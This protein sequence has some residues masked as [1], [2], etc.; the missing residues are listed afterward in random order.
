MD[1]DVARH[2]VVTDL[3][4]SPVHVALLR[5]PDLGSVVGADPVPLVVALHGGAQGAAFADTIAVLASEAWSAG[6]LPPCVIALPHS[7]RS[8]WVDR[9]DGSARWETFVRT[10]LVDEVRALD[11]RCAD[12]P[13]GLLGVSMGGLGVLRLAF[14]YP[15]QFAAVA[16]LEPGIDAGMTWDDIDTSATSVRG[17]AFYEQFHGSPVDVAHFDANHPPAIAVANHDAIVAA[18]IQIYLECG[19]EDALKLY[20]A[21]EL[22][23]RL[24]WDHGI[25]HEYHLVRGADHLGQSLGRRFNEALAFLGRA[26]VPPPPD[27]QVEALRA[28]LA[29]GASLDAV[30]G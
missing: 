23:H 15:E 5:H 9:F 8:F 1:V 12:G 25:K 29:S 30:G 24:L 22:L 11:P 14:K 28:F 13:T 6:D 21:A 4:P 26:F 2:E 19:D 27:P 16:A 17:D 3:V 18:G 20:D 7:G 10:S